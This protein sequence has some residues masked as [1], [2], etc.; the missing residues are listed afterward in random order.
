MAER[1]GASQEEVKELTKQ[2][3]VTLRAYVARLDKE[4]ENRA[5]KSF[6]EIEALLQNGQATWSDAYQIEQLL[7]DLFDERHLEVELQSR[8]LECE[9]NLRPGLAAHYVKVAA[10]LKEPAERRALLARLV[11]DLQWRYT[12]NEVRRT[13]SKDITRITALIFIVGIAAFAAAVLWIA[14]FGKSLLATS[15]AAHLLLAGLAGAWGA[16]FSMLASLKTRMDAADLNDLKL[17]RSKWILWSRPLIGVG[18]ACILYF[19]L[20]SGLLGGAAFPTLQT[21]QATSAASQNPSARTSG[22]VTSEGVAQ[23]PTGASS[24]PQISRRDLALLIV[25]CFI[26]GFSERMVPALLA[27]TETRVSGQS[28]VGPDRFKPDSD[29]ANR[30]AVSPTAKPESPAVPPGQGAPPPK[31]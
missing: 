9:S 21:D 18:A 3:F 2:F 23:T 6:K 16:G 4:D 24:V 8:L 11:N 10:T 31:T 12:V 29:S 28:G 14:V 7:V 27:K 15:D 25:W 30:V 20:V 17:L 1:S 19:F 5:P 13:Y 22:P 26:A